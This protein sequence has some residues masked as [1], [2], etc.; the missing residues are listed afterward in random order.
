MV[1]GT[2]QRT[3]PSVHPGD[4]RVY[5]VGKLLRKP[6][7]R[8]RRGQRFGVPFG[9]VMASRRE[10]WGSRA[11]TEFTP[12]FPIALG[13][14]RADEARRASCPPPAPRGRAGSG[15]PHVRVR[16]L[17]ARAG[18]RM[19]RRARPPTPIRQ[20]SCGSPRDPRACT[21]L[22]VHPRPAPS[23][24]CAVGGK[25]G[26]EADGGACRHRVPVHP[27]RTRGTAGAPAGTA[28][29][30]RR[31]GATT[32]QR[33]GCSWHRRSPG[34]GGCGV[35]GTARRGPGLARPPFPRVVDC[36]VCAGDGSHAVGGMA[37]ARGRKGG[38]DDDRTRAVDH[39]RAAMSLP[40]RPGGSV[41][42][43]NKTLN[44]V[45]KP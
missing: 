7:S 17:A 33:P 23:P 35:V 1:R 41:V 32:G 16:T 21:R 26:L 5:L 36:A 28:G 15:A 37:A 25:Q 8:E 19:R 2:L 3:I 9:P 40:F 11:G 29:H 44:W 4:V 31:P 13:S 27:R 45:L 24:G 30:G 39:G 18:R 12:P 10:P 42:R 34:T 20:R 6:G 22:D 14:R 38:G 43:G